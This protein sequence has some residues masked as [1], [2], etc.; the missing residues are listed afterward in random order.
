MQQI[1]KLWF[2]YYR[3]VIILLC[4]TIICVYIYRISRWMKIERIWSLSNSNNMKIIIF[5]YLKFSRKSNLKNLPWIWLI[6]EKCR[7][8]FIH[9]KIIFWEN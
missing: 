6:N 3:I 9:L 1:E 5:F 7:I 2:L 4:C 8:M